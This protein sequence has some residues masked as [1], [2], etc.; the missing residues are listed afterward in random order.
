ME[1]REGSELALAEGGGQSG[2]GNVEDYN[3]GQT[4]SIYLDVKCT[5]R[6][7]YLYKY[8]SAVVRCIEF[9]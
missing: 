6:F 3:W 7:I 8:T 5:G 1:L 2:K 4:T 9:I